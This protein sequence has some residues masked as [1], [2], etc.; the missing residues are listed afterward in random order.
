MCVICRKRL[1]KAEMTRYTCPQENG[2]SLQVDPAGKRQGRGFYLC[3]SSV[4]MKKFNKFRGWQKKCR[5]E[6][7]DN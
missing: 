6:H 2:T 5:G 4:C 7:Y 3:T 1:P